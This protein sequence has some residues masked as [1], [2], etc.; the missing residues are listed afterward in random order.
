M[1]PQCPWEGDALQVSVFNAAR[2][3]PIDQPSAFKAIYRVLLDRDNGP[4]AGNF[5]SFL[6]REFVLRRFA[7]LPA[8]K[9][10]FWEETALKPE[11]F[12]QWLAKEKPSITG[13]SAKF[14]FA[15]ITPNASLSPAEPS[16][17]GAGV[18][19]FMA[20]MKDGKTHCKRVHGVNASTREWL[21]ELE[22][23]AGIKIETRD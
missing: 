23:K 8:D 20:T 10:K 13:L 7:E 14:D 2:L 17:D 19:E 6:E 5:L 18:I 21:K 12:E 11:A 16:K 3:T 1:L 22:N 4:K 15:A 9:V